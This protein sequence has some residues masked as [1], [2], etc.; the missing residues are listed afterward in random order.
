MPGLAHIERFLILPDPRI[1]TR[2]LDGLTIPDVLQLGKTSSIIRDVVDLYVQTRWNI[3]QFLGM[4]FGDPASFRAT[5]AFTGAVVSGSQALR[6][7]D[8]LP[9]APK[10]DLDIVT[11]V[12]GV[13]A[14]ARFLES[15]GY[16][17]VEREP[18]P[19]DKYPML[20]DVLS[21]TSSKR[22]CNGGGKDGIIEIFDFE[23]PTYGR[24]NQY[25]PV[26]KVQ[27]IAVSQHPVHHIVYTYHSTAVMNYISHKEAVSV[28]PRATLVEKIAY[29]SS[30]ETLGQMWN[31]PWKVKYEK[32]GYLVETSNPRPRLTL[33]GAARQR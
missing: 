12:G 11:R 33:G 6:F 1:R 29:P 3:E 16:T 21:I 27:I 20:I 9:P 2:L 31:P 23:R 14:L 18:H 4:W 24:L 13:T 7:M 28:F 22:F 5:L 25:T 19:Q 30:R 8:R 15:S 17:L 32:R 26:T 10:S